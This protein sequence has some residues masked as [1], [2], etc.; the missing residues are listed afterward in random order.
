MMYREEITREVS[1]EV[2]FI[3]FEDAVLTAGGKRTNSAAVVNVT[4]HQNRSVNVRGAYCF[5]RL[6]SIILPI[7]CSCAKNGL[8]CSALLCF[9][10]P[11]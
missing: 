11:I 10:E 4:T 8:L 1:E 7:A 9:A 2:Y 3:L 5:P 6:R